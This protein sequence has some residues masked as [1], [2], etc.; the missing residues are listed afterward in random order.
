MPATE[1]SSPQDRAYRSKT[2][3]TWV[4]AIAGSL[5][6]HRMYLRGLG[7]PLAWLH[8]PLTMLGMLGVSRMR[9]LGQDDRLSWVLIPVL[10]FMISQGALFAIVYALTPDERWDARHNP[11]VPGRATRWGPV[12]GAISALMV[13]AAVLMGSIA[14]A[15]QKF[16]EWSLQGPG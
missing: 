2:L 7:D 16:F 9:E 11:G 13:G 10:G 8:V 15:V 12:L 6:L 3:A 1:T 4:A 5:G 14:F